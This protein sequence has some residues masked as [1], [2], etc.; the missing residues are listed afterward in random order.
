MGFGVRLHCPIRRNGGPAGAVRIGFVAGTLGC[1]GA[2]RQLLFMLR[3]LRNAGADIKVLCLTRG[4]RYEA[5][6][7]E[8]GIDIEWIGS[9]PS[10]VSRIRNTVKA[11]RSFKPDVIQSA[12]FYT[13]IYSATAG[14]VLQRPNIGAIRND[15][16]SE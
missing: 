2:E 15:V 16:T 14:Y 4:E 8:L 12:H 3:G 13:N 1:G 7:R 10:R 5:P 9:S 6:I 11:L